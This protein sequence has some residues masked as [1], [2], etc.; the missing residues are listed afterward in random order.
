MAL[1]LIIGL[2]SILSPTP[3]RLQI[4]QASLGLQIHAAQQVG[5]ARIGAQG[6]E[7]WVHLDEIYRVV[8]IGFFQPLERLVLLPKARI[9]LPRRPQPSA[10]SGL[11]WPNRN[12]ESC[13]GRDP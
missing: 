9:D 3:G 12:R 13:R 7:G 10:L 11:L 6:I 4:Q 8:L 1:S 5:E 2:A